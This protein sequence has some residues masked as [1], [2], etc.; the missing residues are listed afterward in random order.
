MLL[1]QEA[2]QMQFSRFE[3]LLL[4]AL[5]CRGKEAEIVARA[6]TLFAESVT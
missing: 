2:S 5:S 6:S 4:A 1:T 3:L